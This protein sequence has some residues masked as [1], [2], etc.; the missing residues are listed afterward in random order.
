MD[1]VA[2]VKTVYVITQHCTKKGEPKLV[3]SCSFPLTGPGVVDRIYTE[4]AVIEPT[5]EGFQ[6]LELSPGISLDYVQKRTGARLLPIAESQTTGPS[7]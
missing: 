7:E 1:L 2:G 5:P 3:A 4:L 6:L